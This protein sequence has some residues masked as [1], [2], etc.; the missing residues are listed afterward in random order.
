MDMRNYMHQTEQAIAS[1]FVN[2]KLAVHLLGGVQGPHTLT[3]AIRLYQP[4]KGN[5]AKALALSGAIEARTGLSPVRVYSDQG[6]ILVEVPSP[7]PVVVNGT[8]LRGQG[9]AVPLGMTSRRAIAGVD[10]EKSPHLL[11][12]GPTN[13]GKTTGCRC[14]AYHLAKQLTPRQ[15]QF[16]VSTFKPKD[17]KAF[18]GLAHTMA[19]IVEP[20]ETESMIAWLT[21]L[22]YQRT[23]A[24]I[25]TPHLFVFLDDLLNLLGA[26]DKDIAGSLRE[27]ASLGRGAGIHLIL[28]TQRLGEL[29]AGGAAITGN[30]RTRLVFGTA[31][32]QDAAFFSG[33]SETGAERLGRYA[34][35]ALLINEGSTQRLA[36]GYVTDT[37]LMKLPQSDIN[38]RP[39]Q[40]ND[41]H[42]IDGQRNTPVTPDRNTDSTPEKGAFD[43]CYVTP[44]EGGIMPGNEAKTPR[45]ARNVTVVTR[46]PDAPPTPDEQEYLRVLFTRLGSKRAV[47]KAA[48]GG[49]VNETGNTPKTWRWLNEALGSDEL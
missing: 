6:A 23:R 24:S 14:I 8:T 26:T 32:A 27:L 47:L 7:A 15:A 20:A 31:D 29:G 43:A 1:A 40:R 10:F 42:V 38:G 49:V 35:D 3:Y 12:V 36:V 39:W 16:I 44:L 2:D 13:A 34:G 9:L 45:A 21:N 30:L 11:F 4:T 28:G 22:M 18:A 37:D 48:W 5:V 19:V 41:Q 33:R 46:L 25:D 17:W